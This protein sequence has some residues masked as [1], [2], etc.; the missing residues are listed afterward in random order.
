MDALLKTLQIKKAMDE[1]SWGEKNDQQFRQ[2]LALLGIR[3]QNAKA[4]QSL[5]A[6]FQADLQNNKA[7]DNLVIKAQKDID[8]IDSSLASI[9]KLRGRIAAGEWP[10]LGTATISSLGQLGQGVVQRLYPDS[11][12]LIEQ[13]NTAKMIRK[14]ITTSILN[15]TGKASNEGERKFIIGSEAGA[16]DTKEAAQRYL[17]ETQNAHLYA[18]YLIA[19]NRAKASPTPE[20]GLLVAQRL[21][22]DPQQLAAFKRFKEGIDQGKDSTSD[23]NLL[24]YMPLLGMTPIPKTKK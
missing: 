1:P 2:T 16:F 14:N 9:N 18:R 15:A 21:G 12:E 3:D 19:Y 4:G 5:K 7:A 13:L 8:P 17:D 11:A 20:I 23:E 22:V 10:S 6:G 24:R